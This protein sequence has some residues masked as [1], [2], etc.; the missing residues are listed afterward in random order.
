MKLDLGK[1]QKQNKEKLDSKGTGVNIEGKH[2]EYIKKF[3]I[4]LSSLVRDVLDKLMNESKE[5]DK[6]NEK[7]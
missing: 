6:Q 3:N 7:E 2:L 4:N 5:E 1:H